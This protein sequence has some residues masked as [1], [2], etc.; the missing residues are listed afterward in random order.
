M[1][2]QSIVAVPGV[3]VVAIAQ[4]KLLVALQETPD[5][6][7]AHPSRDEQVLRPEPS[8]VSSESWSA[9]RMFT[10]ANPVVHFQAE[11]M[12]ASCLQLVLIA[13]YFN[14]RVAAGA[15]CSRSPQLMATVT[16]CWAKVME[17]AWEAPMYEQSL[18]V[19]VR[20]GLLSPRATVGRPFATTPALRFNT[21]LHQ[22]ST[23]PRRCSLKNSLS[24]PK[25][26][27]HLGE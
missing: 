17:L 7:G 13:Q 23:L 18:I 15:G 3:R 19:A 1:H 20:V 16:K 26:A 4:A 24:V 21:L 27:G 22:L 11:V 9:R 6:A 8:P 14:S 10:A 12:N 2:A 5:A 25:A